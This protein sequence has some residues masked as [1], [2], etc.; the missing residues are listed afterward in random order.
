MYSNDF[1]PEPFSLSDAL[2]ITA[3]AL[4]LYISS[5]SSLTILIFASLDLILIVGFAPSILEIFTLADALVSLSSTYQAVTT[6][7]SVISIPFSL[8]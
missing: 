5:L 1:N 3:F 6:A 2:T 7:F 4:V 8:S